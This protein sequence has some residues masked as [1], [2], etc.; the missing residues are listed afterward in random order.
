MIQ[1]GDITVRK[2]LLLD[3]FDRELEHMVDGS[4]HPPRGSAKKHVTADSDQGQD[5]SIQSV[6]LGWELEFTGINKPSLL[7]N[8]SQ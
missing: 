2:K 6:L 3:N 1:Y 7:L 4:G 5:V 8:Q